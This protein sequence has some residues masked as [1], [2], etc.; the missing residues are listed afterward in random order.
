MMAYALHADCRLMSANILRGWTMTEGAGNEI[1]ALLKIIEFLEDEQDP[2]VLAVMEER[3][4]DRPWESAEWR[5]E[6]KSLGYKVAARLLESD[7]QSQ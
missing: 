4:P 7:Q 3:Y 5:S 1:T 2:T 6:M